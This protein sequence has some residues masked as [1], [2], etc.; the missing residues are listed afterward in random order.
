MEEAGAVPGGGLGE[1]R[2]GAPGS[3]HEGAAAV[4][5]EAAGHEGAAAVATD[6]RGPPIG[7]Q[8]E[9]DREQGVR[10]VPAA[11]GNKK[12][13]GNKG[14]AGCQRLQEGGGAR[15]V[16]AGSGGGG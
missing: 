14:R 13:T 6:P 5:S 1:R 16:L 11:A 8:Q 9:G 4:A 12:E 10:G 3:R 15:A 2:H 7:M